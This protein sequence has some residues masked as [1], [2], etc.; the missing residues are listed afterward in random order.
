MYSAH[1]AAL[2]R[3]GCDVAEPSKRDFN[4]MSANVGPQI[5]LAPSFAVSASA[6]RV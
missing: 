4:G 5:V 2:R 3:L 6:L 1:A